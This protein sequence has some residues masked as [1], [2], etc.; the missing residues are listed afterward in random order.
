MNNTTMLIKE[1]RQQTGAGFLDCK[2]AL[3]A[4]DG[5]LDQATAFLREKNL[6]KAAKKAERQTVDGL[7]VVK[8]NEEAVCVVELNCETDFVALTPDFK[9]LT[10][11]IADL[12]LADA[13]LT[14]AEKVETAVFPTTNQT[15]H[16]AMQSLIGKLGEN[17][18]LGQIAR[19]KT[20]DNTLV[21][22]YVHAGAI[23]G[24]S[25][26]E[27]RLGVLV[28]VAFA[29]KTAVSPQTADTIAHDLAL[30]IASAAPKYVSVADI[31]TEVLTQQRD[32]LWA[33]VA[34]EKKPDAIKEKMVA[35]R[36]NKF[37]Q[38]NCLLVQPFLKDDSLTVAEWLQGMG[39]V[40]E[41][42]VSVTR[43]TRA[44]IAT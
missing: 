8:A 23:S 30:H 7:I 35:G 12:V 32:R 4:H 5:D 31:P 13:S 39:E 43:F 34:A 25:Q 21:H 22:G 40:V 15:V 37:Y 3:M 2:K 28:E 44:E 41:T 29:D 9:T 14:D 24:Y 18:K 1:L 17:M 36:L 20:T 16:H 38:Q 42:A 10:H 27:G 26:D 33:E 11:R 19:Y 6:S